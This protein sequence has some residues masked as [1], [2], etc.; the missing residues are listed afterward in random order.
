MVRLVILTSAVVFAGFITTATPGPQA[1]PARYQIT[2][3]FKKM[4]G[5]H[6]GPN[7]CPAAPRNGT[8]V[9]SGVVEGSEVFVDDTMEYTGTLSRK[10]DITFC[11]SWRPN[12]R[13]DE[14]CAP[15][16][17]GAQARVKTTIRIWTPKSNQDTEVEFEPLVTSKTDTVNV[18]GAC[19]SDMELDVTQSFLES[20]AFQIVTRNQTPLAKLVAGRSWQD[21]KP[22]PV[23]QPDGWT[24]AVVRKLQ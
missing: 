10:T 5:S 3:T 21:V 9:L 13:E 6:G 19:T 22:R 11:E 14:F 24:L 23:D 1:Q 16:L 7:A 15:R 12:G 2:L 20:D 18:A 8:D 17:T 4:S